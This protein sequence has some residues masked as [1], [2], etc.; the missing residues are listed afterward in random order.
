MGSMFFFRQ[1]CGQLVRE[2]KSNHAHRTGLLQGLHELIRH[3]PRPCG[4]DA[5]VL[6]SSGR[7]SEFVNV[8][9]LKHIPWDFAA[10]P[11]KTYRKLGTS[12]VKRDTNVK[13]FECKFA[14][15]FAPC[16]CWE[17]TQVEDHPQLYLE[18]RHPSKRNNNLE[19][20]NLKGEGVRG[21]API[22]FFEN[23][24]IHPIPGA[25]RSPNSMLKECVV[26]FR[27]VQIHGMEKWSPALGRSFR[28]DSFEETKKSPGCKRLLPMAI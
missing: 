21:G 10:C 26:V 19:S 25:P 8:H 7:G 16:P 27:Q 20:A 2:T 15:Q 22:P 18:K 14:T 9:S 13:N 1:K 5:V 17:C 6:R 11:L 3:L 24:T 4:V 28:L 12:P 23:G